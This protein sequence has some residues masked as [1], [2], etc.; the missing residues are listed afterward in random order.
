VLLPPPLPFKPLSHSLQTDKPI[1]LI[2]L[3]VRQSSHYCMVPLLHGRL[4]V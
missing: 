3:W 2:A 1:V 4:A